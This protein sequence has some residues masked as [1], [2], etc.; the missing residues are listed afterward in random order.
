MR[1]VKIVCEPLNMDRGEIRFT[2]SREQNQRWCASGSDDKPVLILSCYGEVAL[3]PAHVRALLPYLVQFVRMG[4]LEPIRPERKGHWNE[5]SLA[6]MI[7][8]KARAIRGKIS[9]GQPTEAGESAKGLD[10][11]AAEVE[12]LEETVRLL[13]NQQDEE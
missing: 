4:R 2:D 10:W 6:D 3:S 1:P 11:L 5:S 9:S 12:A 8:Q 7:R 13:Q